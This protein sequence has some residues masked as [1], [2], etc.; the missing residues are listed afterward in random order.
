MWCPKGVSFL[1]G[2]VDDESTTDLYTGSVRTFS[3]AVHLPVNLTNACSA[4]INETHF[5]VSGGYSGVTPVPDLWIYDIPNKVWNKMASMAGP[6]HYHG[7]GTVQTDSG[8]EIVVAGGH[9][10][11]AT[12][13]IYNLAIDA[14]R[15]GTNLPEGNK[16]MASV[17][18]EDTLLLVGG[19][20]LVQ[21]HKVMQYQPETEDWLARGEDVVK[22]RYGHVAILVGDDVVDCPLP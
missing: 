8:L 9:N 4:N 20:S 13:E 12:T 7:C 14:W 22:P 6:R 5:F 15:P 10:D 19:L 2:G 1:G 17:K 18:Y 3:S 21:R 11:I 16:G